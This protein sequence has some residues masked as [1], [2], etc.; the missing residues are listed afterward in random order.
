MVHELVE[1]VTLEVQDSESTV[2]AQGSF[3]YL[4]IAPD[5]EVEEMGEDFKLPDREVEDSVGDEGNEIDSVDN[6]PLEKPFSCED[7]VSRVKKSDLTII[8]RLD[9]IHIATSKPM[10]MQ[11]SHLPFTNSAIIPTQNVVVSIPI[12]RCGVILPF[13]HF[14][15]AILT[16]YDVSPFQLT[17]NSYCIILGFYAMYM[18]YTQGEPTVND[19]SYFYDMKNVGHDNGFYCFRKRDSSKLQEHKLIPV[20]AK[21]Q[22][23]PIYKEPSEKQKKKIDKCLPNRLQDKYQ[24]NIVTPSAATPQKRKS[25]VTTTLEVDLSKK[26][27]KVTQDKGKKA[28]LDIVA[29]DKEVEDLNRAKNQAEEKAKKSEEKTKKLEEE[30]VNL[31]HNLEGE[32]ENA[33]KAYD[34]AVFDYI[35]TTLTKLPDFDS[36]FL[37]QRLFRWLMLFTPYLLLRLKD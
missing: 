19:F 34:Q 29:K 24:V 6:A 30:I 16:H 36:Y 8:K 2:F 28:K 33:K 4:Q 25:K 22:Q 15:K 14:V 5:V 31:I 12:L 21:L 1:L 20:D 27:Q 26:H 32:K 11:R 18:E 17:P 9:L 37:V 7:L 23:E 3:A 35:Y 10:S 13:H